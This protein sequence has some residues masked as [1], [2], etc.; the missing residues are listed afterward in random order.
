MKLKPKRFMNKSVDLNQ[1]N[2]SII[3]ND[4]TVQNAN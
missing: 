1:N 2:N 4:S 3:I